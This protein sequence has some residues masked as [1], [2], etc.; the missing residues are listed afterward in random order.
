MRINII[1]PNSAKEETRPMIEFQFISN[2]F[3][4]DKVSDTV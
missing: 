3:F 2:W 4:Q 1:G